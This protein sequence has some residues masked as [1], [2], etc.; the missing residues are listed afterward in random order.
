MAPEQTV[1]RLNH[2]DATPAG[3]ALLSFAHTRSA[4]KWFEQGFDAAQAGRV[5]EA[6]VLYQHAIQADP[7][8]CSPRFNTG[9][10]LKR[11]GRLHEAATCFRQV[12]E[13]EPSHYKALVMLGFL[14]DEQGDRTTARDFFQAATREN[15]QYAVAFRNL[16]IVCRELGDHQR[17]K[18]ADTRYRELTG[19]LQRCLATQADARRSPDLRPAPTPAQQ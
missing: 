19:E 13:I 12:L 17:A 1:D 3:D 4:E 2:A 7:G 9:I 10:L 5:D 15:D 11:L 14:A 18:Q 16:A 8:Y 6:L